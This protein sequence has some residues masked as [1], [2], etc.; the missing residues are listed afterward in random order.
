MLKATA[1]SEWYMRD[2]NYGRM[3]CRSKA[4]SVIVSLKLAPCSR[5]DTYSQWVIHD[6]CLLRARCC[7]KSATPVVV[8]TRGS[9]QTLK[10]CRAER[11][12]AWLPCA[13]RNPISW[14]CVAGYRTRAGAYIVQEW[15]D[16]WCCSRCHPPFLD[17]R[18]PFLAYYQRSR[19]PGHFC[20]FY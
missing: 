9:A 15:G 14:Y 2:D 18:V 20:F 11:A 1:T 13:E 10:V 5:S 7:L 4:S 16:C 12:E 17:S 3:A 19:S 8:Y 6:P